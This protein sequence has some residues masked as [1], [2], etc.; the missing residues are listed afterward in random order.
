MIIPI[1]SISTL[2]KNYEISCKYNSFQVF[3]CLYTHGCDKNVYRIDDA[4]NHL[5]VLSPHLFLCKIHSFLA[6]FLP[7]DTE[8]SM[9]LK[10]DG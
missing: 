4:S 6:L 5:N 2:D 3:V 8:N 9:C 10:N 7:I 1:L